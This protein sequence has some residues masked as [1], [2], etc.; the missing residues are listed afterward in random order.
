MRSLQVVRKIFILNDQ[1]KNDFLN[2]DIVNQ[3]N[4]NRGTKN[5][6]RYN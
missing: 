4:F 5:Q 6:I 1:E 3:V 2:S